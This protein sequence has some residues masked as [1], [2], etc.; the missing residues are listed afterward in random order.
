M[1]ADD[2]NR[3]ARLAAMAAMA[4][5]AGMFGGLSR[6]FRG[7]PHTNKPKAKLFSV[8]YITSGKHHAWC[9]SDQGRIRKPIGS[10]PNGLKYANRW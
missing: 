2:T 7:T 9:D 6:V 1:V 5:M 8:L 4:A 3:Y 10:I